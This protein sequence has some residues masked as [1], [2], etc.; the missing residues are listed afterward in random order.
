MTK[1]VWEIV[2]P[3]SATSVKQLLALLK[4]IGT[5]QR[6]QD[7]LTKSGKTIVIRFRA[8]AN[9]L[10]G[11]HMA[12]FADD[13][14]R[15]RSEAELLRSRD[16]LRRFS[17]RIES[18]LEEERARISREL[19]DRLGQSLAGL[20]FEL[21]GLLV[22]VPGAKGRTLKTKVSDLLVSIDTSIADVRKLARDLRPEIL[23]RVGLLAAA[24]FSSHQFARESGIRCQL[25]SQVGE[26]AFEPAE[27]TALYRIIQEALSNVRLHA[28]ATAV[29]IRIAAMPSRVVLTIADNGSG[30]STLEIASTSSLGLIGM[31]ERAERLGGKF[32]ITTRRPH[33][34]VV[35]AA[36]PRHHL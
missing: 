4:R 12:I 1:S 27:A 30:I 9:I 11:R 15:I 31:R 21:Q 34:T 22:K 29:T 20:R 8:V 3:E 25:I 6:H 19:H 14:S 16:S 35:R 28:Q 23:D 18:L 17:D 24:E 5:L 2:P 36:I 7:L 10:P 32:R 13:T 33:G 26:T